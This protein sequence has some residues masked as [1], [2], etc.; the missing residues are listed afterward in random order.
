MTLEIVSMK[1]NRQQPSPLFWV[2]MGWSCGVAPARAGGAVSS[3]S[4]V[5]MADCNRWRFWEEGIR[6]VDL[7]HRGK[8]PYL[9]IYMW[10]IFLG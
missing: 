1:V 4:V 3:F 7:S 10:M 9:Y 5:P 6:E 2:L 8:S